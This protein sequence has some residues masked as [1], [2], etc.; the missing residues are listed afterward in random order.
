MKL[1]YTLDT[2]VGPRYPQIDQILLLHN[3]KL[4]TSEQNTEYPITHSPGNTSRAMAGLQKQKH[5]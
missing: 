5:S 2:G 1:A 3:Q 4:F